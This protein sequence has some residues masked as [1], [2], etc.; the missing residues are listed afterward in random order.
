MSTRKYAGSRELK[1]PDA[2]CVSKSE[3]NRRFVKELSGL[4]EEF[5]NRRIHEDYPIMML[6]GMAVG[7]MTVIA[8]MGIGCD[9]RKRMLGLSAGGTENQEAIKELLTD[10][11]NRGLV[12]GRPRL[13]VLDGGK[14]LHKAVT[15]TFGKHAVIQRC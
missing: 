6:D 11:L 8:A 7:K 4:M 3:V 1:E 13:F 10:L 14:A 2:T 15:D 5:F 12:P 9:G